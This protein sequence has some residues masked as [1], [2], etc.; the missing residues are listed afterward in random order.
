[1]APHVLQYGNP[2]TQPMVLMPL[3]V[4]LAVHQ[5]AQQRAKGN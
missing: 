5:A 1:M 2:L 3:Q 4:W